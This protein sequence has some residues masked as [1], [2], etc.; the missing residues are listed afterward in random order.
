MAP[1]RAAEG[2]WLRSLAGGGKA[3]TLL[4]PARGWEG[5]LELEAL[6]GE[7]GRAEDKPAAQGQL[8]SWLSP[9]ISHLHWL[10][11]TQVQI[12]GTGCCSQPGPCQS[13]LLPLFR[14][15]YAPAL[16]LIPMCANSTPS[17]SRPCEPTPLG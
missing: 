4:S 2:S 5:P 16:S 6:A 12:P 15:F 10:P 13:G 7:A 17:P 8:L 14:F 9:L 11:I 3:H 1:F